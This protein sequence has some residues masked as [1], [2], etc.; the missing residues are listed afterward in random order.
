L[1]FFNEGKRLAASGVYGTI[2]L[3]DFESADEDKTLGSVNLACGIN[4]FG[5]SPDG[6]WLACGGSD[7]PDNPYF[8]RL[9]DGEKGKKYDTFLVHSSII[10]AIAFSPDG[11]YLASG[12]ED[13]QVFLWTKKK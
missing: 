1:S 4:C 13:G 10:S 3:W 11:K 5:A 6:K 8:V 2:K 9:I 12:A 7:Y